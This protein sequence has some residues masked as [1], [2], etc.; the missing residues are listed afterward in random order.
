MA[1]QEAGA[2]DY[3]FDNAKFL[4]I[5]LVVMGHA[6]VPYIG[7][8]TGVRTLYLIIYSFHMPLFFLI[9]GYFAKK[10]IDRRQ[11]LKP[12]Q[13]ILLPYLLFQGIYAVYYYFIEDR[14][15]VYPLLEP[16]WSLWFLLSL[17]TF[18]VLMVFFKYSIYLLVPAVLLGML[19]GV[20]EIAPVLSISR[21]LVFFPFFL[22]GYFMKKSWMNQVRTIINPKISIIVFA[23]AAVLLYPFADNIMFE[24]FYGSES[25][26]ALGIGSGAGMMVR[27]ALY[28]VTII[29]S[30]CFLALVPSRPT[31]FSALALNTMY[32]YLLHGFLIRYLRTTEFY[33]VF[34]GSV[35]IMLYIAAA[36]IYTF[37]LSSN[38]VKKIF[39]P[40]IEPKRLWS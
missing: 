2:R 31:V 14:E 33:T 6:V 5:V 40:V 16:L 11:F 8:H 36:V 13:T 20:W 3:F 38:T 23:G 24:W 18:Y 39:W 28:I 21:T 7:E 17:F 35:E 10:A 32:V 9:A 29:V 15:L 26:A 4:L 27:L 19:A 30:L 37:V 25:Y 12:V 22:L 34:N 1:A